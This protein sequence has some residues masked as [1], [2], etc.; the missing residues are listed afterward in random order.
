[1]T[2]IIIQARMGSSRLPGKVMKEIRN[3]PL[4][5]YMINQVKACT[6]VSEIIIATTT[7]N[8]DE[9]I[10]SFGNSIGVKVFR[11][12]SEDVLDR[13]H[14]CAGEH[15]SKDIV[16]LCA[17]SPFIDYN[18]I[19]QC[20]SKFQESNVDYLSNTIKKK[21]NGWIEGSNGFPIGMA[22]EVFTSGALEKAWRQ[23]K[24]S[25]DREHVTEYIFHNP[26]LFRLGN[27]E[28]NEDLSDLRLVVDY[29]EDFE[30]T[31]KII[32]NFEEGQLFT[33][34]K[35]KEFLNKNPKLKMI[36]SMYIK[37]EF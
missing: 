1:M 3:K 6:K 22:V 30:L 13:Y 20:I 21:N 26:S 25:S 23:A 10:V 18:V 2:I 27:I 5:Y 16:R 28:N 12:S 19:D 37:N 8:E 29:S 36:N 15:Q 7:L 4:L 14:S 32:T 34:K 24:K 11:G 9:K 33:I 17:D 31:T 35:L